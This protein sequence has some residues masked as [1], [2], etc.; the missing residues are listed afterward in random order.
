MIRLDI[1]SA[2]LKNL[3]SWLLHISVNHLFLLRRKAALC[4]MLITCYVKS[5][6]GFTPQAEAL[7]GVEQRRFSFGAL[8]NLKY[9]GRRA[10]Q[11]LFLRL[12]CFLHK[13]QTIH[14]NPSRKL[15]QDVKK[16][17]QFSKYN[18]IFTIKC[19]N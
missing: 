9:C 11:R 1:L 8:V 18:Q 10:V 7:G 13:P 15:C 2:I 3:N 6:A 17:G 14:V 19:H 12:V 16:F 4:S 5:N